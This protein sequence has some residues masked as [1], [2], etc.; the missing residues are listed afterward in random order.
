MGRDLEEY[1]MERQASYDAKKRL[2]ERMGEPTTADRSQ[3][4]QS[5]PY[6]TIG[7]AKKGAGLFKVS[8][9]SIDRALD[10]LTD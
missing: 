2:R 7:D 8:S 9:N 10:Q 6:F 1:W 5:L 3:G 4:T